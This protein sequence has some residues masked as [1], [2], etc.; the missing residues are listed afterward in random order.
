MEVYCVK[1]DEKGT[2]RWY[3]NGQYHRTDGGPAIECKDNYKA[4]YQYGK[5]DRT[6]GPAIENADG[7]KEWFIGGKEYTQDEFDKITKISSL[8]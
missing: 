7:S 4:W 3:Q 1:I 2:I 8:P 6:D 5:L